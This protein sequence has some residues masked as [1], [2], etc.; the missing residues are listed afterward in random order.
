MIPIALS[1]RIIKNTKPVD[2][3]ERK[4][5]S[6]DVSVFRQK[7]EERYL[8][9]IED[10]EVEEDYLSKIK[11]EV[12]NSLKQEMESE[13]QAL[14]AAAREEIE[15]ERAEAVA[16]GNQKGYEEGFLKG[17]ED[18]YE[19]TLSFRENAI[20]MLK[21][22]EEMAKDYLEANEEKII[23]L[24]SRIAE[25]IV[26]V[27]LDHNDESVMLLARPILQEYGKTENVI[28]TCHPGKVEFM[29]EHTHE[30]EK[31]CPNAHILILQDRNLDVNDMVIE[32][33]NQITDLT[34]SKQI[35]RFIKLAT[36]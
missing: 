16:K 19:E 4:L 25:K 5:E 17:K 10:E 15:K 23:K 18:G 21:D 13:R 14:M 24:S 27:T 9:A 29:K 31:M 26:Q 3:Q 6:L 20:E 34:I 8:E 1:Y 36:E 32:N 33:E 12:R 2:Q 28:I 30:I 7:N 35:A 22:A 11:R